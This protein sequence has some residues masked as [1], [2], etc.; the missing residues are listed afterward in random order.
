VK[1]VI[2]GV[3]FVSLWACIMFPPLF[4]VPL[5]VVVCLVATRRGRRAR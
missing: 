5:I 1:P 2:A 4:L 3:A